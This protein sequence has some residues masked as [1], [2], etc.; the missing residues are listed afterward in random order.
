[1]NRAGRAITESLVLH[2][3]L[4]GCVIAL[5]GLFPS[6]P[7]IIRL[8]FSL[9]ERNAEPVPSEALQ[10]NVE[11]ITPAV[12]TPPMERQP[13]PVLKAQRKTVANATPAKVKPQPVS[14]PLD[15]PRETVVEAAPATGAGSSETTPAL[16][17]AQAGG[18][19]GEASREGVVEAYRRANFSIIRSAILAH[20]HYPM[21]ARRQGWSGKVEIAFLVT[22]EGG[23]GELRIK[24]SSGHMVLDEEAMAAIRRSAPFTPPRVAALLVMPVTFELN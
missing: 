7:P 21:I 10:Q 4:T 2:V 5:A 1:M 8:D 15:V 14:K 20:L 24:K 12:A 18:S 13:T 11:S 3:L 17:A 16:E 6:P 9:V 23:V 19:S 22:P